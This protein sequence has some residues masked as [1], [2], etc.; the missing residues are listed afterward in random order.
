MSSPPQ[1]SEDTTASITQLCPPSTNNQQKAKALGHPDHTLVSDSLRAALARLNVAQMSDGKENNLGYS[2][3]SVKN[4]CSGSV[5]NENDEPYYSP[6]GD[7][8]EFNY[9]PRR[10]RDNDNHSPN[11]HESD[12]DI[13]LS[14]FV[15][16][17]SE[18]SISADEG[19]THDFSYGEGGTRSSKSAGRV[20]DNGD[21]KRLGTFKLKT[22]H[23]SSHQPNGKMATLHFLHAHPNQ[24]RQF[25]ETPKSSRDERS[26]IWEEFLQSRGLYS[27]H[28]KMVRD[29]QHI[30]YRATNVQHKDTA[31]AKDT[32][33]ASLPSDGTESRGEVVEDDLDSEW[34]L[35]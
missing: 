5:K 13:N 17:H 2:A 35:I 6:Q 24:R 27:R 32:R 18:N 19:L 23:N 34:V 15:G 16:F 3:D 7:E 30:E 20:N 14:E 11:R 26:S 12:I 31:M 22:T 29:S 1:P 8:D 21:G 28:Q 33:L 9:G 4:N 25:A 10:A